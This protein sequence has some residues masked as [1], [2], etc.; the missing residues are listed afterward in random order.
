[1][2]LLSHLRSLE[3]LLLAP[4]H[5]LDVVCAVGVDAH[6]VPLVCPVPIFELHHHHGPKR[7]LPFGIEIVSHFLRFYQ[8]YLVAPHVLLLSGTETHEVRPV[9]V[10]VVDLRLVRKFFVLFIPFRGRLDLG[11]TGN[12][13]QRVV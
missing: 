1:M 5:E 4:V 7:E 3:V 12:V 8:I 13:A 11:G 9:A 6:D 10:P 2:R